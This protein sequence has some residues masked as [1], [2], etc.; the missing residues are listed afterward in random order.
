MAF[1]LKVKELLHYFDRDNYI[2]SEYNCTELLKC[3]SF[4][5]LLGKKV[6]SYSTSI[7][8]TCI[9]GCVRYIYVICSLSYKSC[10]IRMTI[11]SVQIQYKCLIARM[12]STITARLYQSTCTYVCTYCAITVK[13]CLKHK[14]FHILQNDRTR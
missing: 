11:W 5:M 13:Y 4:S 14:L 3:Y 8:V 9:L 12:K 7:R 1:V 10:D 2:K 6:T